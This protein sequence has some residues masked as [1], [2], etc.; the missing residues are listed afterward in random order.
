MNYNADA[1]WASMAVNPN[2]ETI[3]GGTGITV[4][5]VRAIEISDPV[6]YMTDDGPVKDL[7]ERDVAIATVVH[8]SMGGW[9]HQWIEPSMMQPD[10]SNPF[11]YGSV[12]G[13]AICANFTATLTAKAYFQ[14]PKPKNIKVT[15]DL[16]FKIQYCMSTSAAGNVGLIFSYDIIQSGDNFSTPTVSNTKNETIAPPAVQYVL[17]NHTSAT[18][19]ITAAELALI[20]SDHAMIVC[21]IT[22]D[23]TVGSNHAG[24]FM[25]VGV[26]AYQP[27]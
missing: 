5:K 19:T 27:V 15:E 2:T 4:P 20:P 17:N 14:F 21:S 22:R 13:K 16:N 6:Y 10:S 7:K 12:A 9:V 18:F 23:I 25:L 24:K 26:T 8:D 3:G 1:F 11:E